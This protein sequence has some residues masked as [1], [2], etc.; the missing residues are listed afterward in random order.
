ML[1][2]EDERPGNEDSSNDMEMDDEPVLEQ[3]MEFASANRGLAFFF[4][5]S[6]FYIKIYLAVDKKNQG[7]EKDVGYH[8]FHL[9]LFGC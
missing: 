4:S 3:I 1:K 7:N 2:A 9:H 8:V 5:S 6:F